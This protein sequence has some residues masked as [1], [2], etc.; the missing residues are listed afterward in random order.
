V[1]IDDTIGAV[2][3]VPLMFS[4]WLPLKLVKVDEA[5]DII[6]DKKTGLAIPCKPSEPGEVS[7]IL[8]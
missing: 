5:G 7:F 3:F 8:R 6:R 4:S 2:G 1:N